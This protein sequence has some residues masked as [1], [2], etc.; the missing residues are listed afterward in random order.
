MA[1]KKL[2]KPEID[3]IVIGTVKRVTVHSVFID[4]DEYTNIEGMIHISEIAPGRIRNIRDYV[5]EGKKIICKVLNINKVT[6]NIDLSLRRVTLSQRIE[7]SNELKQEVKAEKLV[8]SL[9]V[10]LKLNQDDLQKKILVKATEKYGSLFNFFQEIVTNGKVAFEGLNIPTNISDE[11][12]NL[13]KEKMRAPEVSINGIL[14]ISTFTSN[15]VDEL[16]KI[17][18]KIAATGI[19]ISYLG[20]P[21][22]RLE[23]ISD[24]L[25]KADKILTNAL[26][27]ATKEIEAIDG[28]L[29]FEKHD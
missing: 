29:K 22:Y 25:K 18:E 17:L 6:G 14:T 15:G 9:A 10:K 11:L 2:G 1:Y 24:N 26:E 21:N 27:Q 19:K 3:E 20:A 16:K 23:I 4:L 28:T 7:K 12:F 5:K 13:V 8:S